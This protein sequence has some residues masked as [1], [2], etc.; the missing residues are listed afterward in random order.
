MPHLD[1]LRAIAV[2]AVLVHHFSRSGIPLAANLGVKLF[3]V[4]SGFLITGLLLHARERVEQGRTNRKTALKNF[5]ARRFLRIFPLYYAVIGVAILLNIT[6]AREYAPYLLSYTLNLKMAAQGWYV[7]NFAHFWSLC[8]EEQFYLVWPWL[9]ILASKRW[10]LPL[11]VVMTMLGPAYRLYLLLGWSYF[12]LDTSGLASYIVTPTCFDSLGM[13]ALLAILTRG[14]RVADRTRRIVLD[15]V[16]PIGAIVAALLYVGFLFGLPGE[17]L[18]GDTASAIVFAWVVS[19]G[20]RGFG[21]TAGRI[22]GWGPIRYIGRISY[23]IYVYHPLVFAVIAFGVAEMGLGIDERSVAGITMGFLL[24]LT[25]AT[26]S[27]FLMERPVNELKRYFP[28]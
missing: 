20:A 28:S 22:I 6:V 23:G 24:T 11:V 3:F 4:L 1:G 5:Y 26:A 27:W 12:G 18:F 14:D 15:R 8:V 2:S 13:G 19:R 16:L 21:G 17:L 10:L 9:L 7:Q 25:I